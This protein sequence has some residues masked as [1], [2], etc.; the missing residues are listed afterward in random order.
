[1]THHRVAQLR[2]DAQIAFAPILLVEQ[3]GEIAGR[4]QRSADSGARER[5]DALAFLPDV[6]ARK[7]QPGLRVAERDHEFRGLQNEPLIDCANEVEIAVAIVVSRQQPD[8]ERGFVFLN[9]QLLLPV[10]KPRIP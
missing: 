3:I 4:V 5:E 10:S 1:M 9:R 8:D 7:R 6:K 2:G